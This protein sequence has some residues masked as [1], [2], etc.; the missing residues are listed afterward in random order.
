MLARRHW[1]RALNGNEVLT[2]AAVSLGA[3]VLGLLA[4]G[5]LGTMGLLIPLA[6]VL[7]T[8]AACNAL[9][10]VM[11]VV[12]L[13]VL[14]E[15]SDFGLFPFQSHIYD[16]VYK[17]LTWVDLLVVF[18]IFTV[19]VD[20]IRRGHKIR[21]PK[22]LVLGMTMLALGMVAG[23]VTGHAAGAPIR[24][25]LV[26]QNVLAYLLLLPIAVANLDVDRRQI[27]L[28]LKGA[29]GLAILKAL[30]GLV[31]LAGGYSRIVVE[32]LSKLTYYEPTANYLIM[33]ALLGLVAAV[34]ER[35]RLSRWMVLGSPLLIGSLVLS[36]RR[37]F[38]I[39]SVLGIVLTYLLGTSPNGRR[40][41]VPVGLLVAVAIW[42]VGSIGVQPQN[43]IVQRA[44]S[45]SLSKLEA[46]AEDRYRLDERANVL[47]EIRQHPLTGLGLT[48]SWQATARPLPVEHENGRQY[49]H[50]AALWFWLKLGVLGLFA[51][52]GI[53]LGGMVLAL[54]AWRRSREPL[55]RAFGL[56]SLAGLVGLVVLDTTASF[57]GVEGRFTVLLGAQLGLLA[58]IARTAPSGREDHVQDT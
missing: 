50:F 39:A 13:T 35:A 23:A 9:A 33:I 4:P 25:V 18:A 2:A 54:Q 32:G 5:R 20:A 15:G 41:L 37:S 34:V 3:L 21:V 14:C 12:G 36:Y 6:L 22:P 16:Q 40:M 8:V 46:N 17:G 10:T 7:L 27:A 30:L 38:W 53:I 11:F 44:A 52:V 31:E 55:L 19:I 49:V 42:L 48:I 1:S 47:H 24:S 29:M 45:L 28:L 26:S 43:P 51:Y 58:L 57:T 56:A